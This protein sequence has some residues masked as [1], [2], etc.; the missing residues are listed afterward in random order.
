MTLDRGDKGA[1]YLVAFVLSGYRLIPLPRVFF[2]GFGFTV[3]LLLAWFV[4]QVVGMGWVLLRRLCFYV[5]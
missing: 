1:L 5:L 2:C 3:D 4:G